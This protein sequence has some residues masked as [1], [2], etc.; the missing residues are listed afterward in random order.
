MKSRRGQALSILEDFPHVSETR[1]KFCSQLYS[2]KLE[3]TALASIVICEM[4]AD[5]NQREI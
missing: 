5:A 1:I 4:N 2:Y 3:M